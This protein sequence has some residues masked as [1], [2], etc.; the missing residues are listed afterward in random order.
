MADLAGSV[1]V[2]DTSTL[3]F[4]DEWRTSDVIPHLSRQHGEDKEDGQHAPGGLV[5]E[6]L[7]VV[8][9]QV[10]QATNQPKQDKEGHSA[11]VVWRSEHADVHLRPLIYPPSYGLA[12]KPNSLNIH[13][14]WLF[15]LP[16]FI[17]IV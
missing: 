17:R 13:V 1:D 15:G 14:V 6:E 11:S 5:E 2:R 9:P 16:L 7:Q 4:V 12:R 8:P 10:H 3:T